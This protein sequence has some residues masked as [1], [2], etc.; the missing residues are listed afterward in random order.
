MHASTKAL[1]VTAGLLIST[2]AI[3]SVAQAT[4][5]SPAPYAP[6]QSNVAAGT[7]DGPVFIGSDGIGLGDPER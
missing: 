6:T 5:P 1:A 3:V 4:P 7:L 2:G